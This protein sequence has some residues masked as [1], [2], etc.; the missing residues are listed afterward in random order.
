MTRDKQ[1]Y[2]R[3]QQQLQQVHTHMH[4]RTYTLKQICTRAHIHI[5]THESIHRYRYT[6]ILTYTH[7]HTHIHKHTHTQ[8]CTTVI[9]LPSDTFTNRITVQRLGFRVEFNSAGFCRTFP[10]AILSFKLIFCLGI[11]GAILQ[12][13]VTLSHTRKLQGHAHA[14]NLARDNHGRKAV[15]PSPP[16]RFRRTLRGGGGRV[17]TRAIAQQAR[18]PPL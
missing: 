8:T 18:A 12:A 2:M 3:L 5:Y 16:L 17:R 6:H 7:T 13:S 9:G 14:A 11:T 10:L 1:H 15:P 4:I